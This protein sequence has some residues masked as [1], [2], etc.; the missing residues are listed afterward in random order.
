MVQVF[1]GLING[2]DVPLEDANKMREAYSIAL[3]E[4]DLAESQV[5]SRRKLAEIIVHLSKVELFRKADQM[6]ALAVSWYQ[7]LTR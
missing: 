7:S 3:H 1:E 2:R 6:A 5:E 4:L